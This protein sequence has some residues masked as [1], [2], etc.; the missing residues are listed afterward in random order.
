MDY[1]DFKNPCQDESAEKYCCNLFKNI[2][3]GEHFQMLLEIMKHSYIRNF[4]NDQEKVAFFNKFV[5]KGLKNHNLSFTNPQ[6]SILNTILFTNLTTDFQNAKSQ[7]SKMNLV[8]TGHGICY[9]YNS[10][11]MHQIYQPSHYLDMWNLTFGTGIDEVLEYPT[12]WGPARPLY[13]VVQSFEPSSEKTSHGFMLSFTNE[14]NPYDDTQNSFE[15]MPGYQHTFRVIPSQ[16]ST[17]DHF[18][19]LKLGDRKCKLENENEGMR[20]LRR[21]SKSGC[22]FECAIEKSLEICSCLPWSVPRSGNHYKT[23]DMFGNLCFKNTFNSPQTYEGCS[24]MS[25]CQATTYIISESSKPISNWIELCSRAKVISQLADY[26]HEN[27]NLYFTLSYF[28]NKRGPDPDSLLNVCEF[29]ITNHV[30]VIKVEI[31]A[32]SVIKSVRDVKTTFENQLSAIGRIFYL[33]LIIVFK[34]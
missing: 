24:C 8:I 6:P 33:F 12:V 32:K 3:V 13:I 7:N 29:L 23:C 5:L 4:K 2:T 26:I 10:L 17:T 9:S 11:P 27:Y 22:E 14:Y 18:D 28:M 20:L 25:D 19:K 31:G 34:K 16:L 15:I 21:F 30:S 1:Q